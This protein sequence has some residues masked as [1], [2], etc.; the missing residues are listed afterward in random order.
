MF[1]RSLADGS[2]VGGV[3]TGPVFG[4]SITR[5]SGPFVE[6]RSGFSARGDTKRSGGVGPFAQKIEQ[7]RSHSLCVTR[8]PGRSS[9]R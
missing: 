1:S 9:S 2:F 6:P 4:S 3:A 5:K 8:L 7:V